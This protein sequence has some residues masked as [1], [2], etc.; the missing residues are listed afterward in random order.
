MLLFYA[1]ISLFCLLIYRKSLII[2]TTILLNYKYISFIT[3]Y[4]FETVMYKYIIA[5]VLFIILVF[6]RNSFLPLIFLYIYTLLVYATYLIS[7]IL[8]I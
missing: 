4:E 5:I 3:D 8:L 7:K 2:L 1:I 6:R